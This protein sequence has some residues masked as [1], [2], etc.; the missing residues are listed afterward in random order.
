[1]ATNFGTNQYR[2]ETI[3]LRPILTSN[4]ADQTIAIGS[5]DIPSGI[6]N[7]GICVSANVTGDTT[8]IELFPFTDQDQSTV[9]A[10]YGYIEDDGGTSTAAIINLTGGGAA[11]SFIFRAILSFDATENLQQHLFLPYGL[12]L[13]LTDGAATDG[14][15]LEITLILQRV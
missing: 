8:D 13:V 3:I 11:E 2:P 9:G 4:N 5:S 14:E 12:Q 15:L 1:M 10:A 7:I 6:Y